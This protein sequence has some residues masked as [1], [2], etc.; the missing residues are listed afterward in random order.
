MLRGSRTTPLGEKMVVSKYLDLV[1]KWLETDD[2]DDLY[3]TRTRTAG[4]IRVRVVR[5]C[6]HRQFKFACS[7][8]WRHVEISLS[9]SLPLSLPL[10]LSLYIYMY[11]PLTINF[12]LHFFTLLKPSWRTEDCAHS[13]VSSRKAHHSTPK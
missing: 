3:G 6:S 5:S 13:A 12:L 4:V 9:L 10:S 2:G 8:G 1:H 7:K 11:V